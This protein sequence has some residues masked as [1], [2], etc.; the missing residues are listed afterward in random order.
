MSTGS[1]G[2]LT[3]LGLR[4]EDA[5]AAPSISANFPSENRDFSVATAAQIC[6]QILQ[7]QDNIRENARQ[8]LLSLSREGDPDLFYESLFHLARREARLH[9]AAA[10]VGS[11]FQSLAEDRR[12]A[13]P[14][15]L[16][17]RAREELAL[18]QG[19]GSFGRRFENFTTHFVEEA[20]DPSMIAGMALGGIAFSAVRLGVM[21]RFAVRPAAWW[22]RGLGA[23]FLASSA[24][25]PA[26]VL[27]FWGSGRAIN[28]VRHPGSLRWDGETLRNELISQTLTLGLL[29][30]SGAASTRLF[31][32]FHGI[33]P[34]TGQALRLPAFTHFSRQAFHQLGMFGGIVGGHYVETRLQLRPDTGN[35]W[36][37]SLMTL[38]H[39]NVGGRVANTV[40]GPGHAAR[41]R[42]IELQTQRI[43]SAVEPRSGSGLFGSQ[44]I[45]A[46]TP[47]GFRVSVPRKDARLGPSIVQMSSHEGGESRS[48]IPH[49]TYKSVIQGIADE[50][51]PI[52]Q[53]FQMS[54]SLMN[55][56]E[57]ARRVYDTDFAR[58]ARFTNWR[59]L[60]VLLH[61]VNKRHF[62]TVSNTLFEWNDRFRFLQNELRSQVNTGGQRQRRQVRRLLDSVDLKFLETRRYLNDAESYLGD[63]KGFGDGARSKSV[64]APN[65]YQRMLIS[66]FLDINLRLERYVQS[67]E[68]LEGIFKG[69]RPNPI[70]R[71]PQRVEAAQ[72]DAEIQAIALVPAFERI[73]RRGL[74][75]GDYFLTGLENT[76]LYRMLQAW[77]A[78]PNHRATARGKRALERYL[79]VIDEVQQ[80]LGDRG[81]SQ[82]LEAHEEIA[83]DRIQTDAFRARIENV[84]KDHGDPEALTSHYIRAAEGL[85]GHLAEHRPQPRAP[86]LP[87]WPELRSQLLRLRDRG[88][89]GSDAVNG[90]LTWFEP[91]PK[92]RTSRLILN[93]RRE[94]ASGLIDFLRKGSHSD[95]TRRQISNF[96]G[97]VV[98][99]K[100]QGM[101]DIL[102]IY[103]QTYQ[104]GMMRDRIQIRTRPSEDPLSDQ[105]AVEAYDH[106]LEAMCNTARFYSANRELRGPYFE[107]FLKL[108]DS[109]DNHAL[110][111]API[112]H[113][114]ERLIEEGFQVQLL[115]R[116]GSG[117]GLISAVHPRGG[118]RRTITVS[119][120]IHA[121][122][123]REHLEQ[124]LNRAER[125][126]LHNG[127]YVGNGN[128]RL[129]LAL[130]IPHIRSGVRRENLQIWARDYLE[131]HP[132]LAE[133]QLNVPKRGNTV[134]NPTD[135]TFFETVK[136]TREALTTE[137][138][139]GSRLQALN[140]D[141]SP[142]PEFAAAIQMRRGWADYLAN[143][144]PDLFRIFA[145]PDPVGFLE[146]RSQL[147]RDSLAAQRS[148]EPSSE[149]DTAQTLIRIDSLERRLTQTE[150]LL[151]AARRAQGLHQDNWD[152]LREIAPRFSD[153][154]GYRDL[155]KKLWEERLRTLDRSGWNYLDTEGPAGRPEPYPSVEVRADI[156]RQVSGMVVG[157]E[158]PSQIFPQ[159]FDLSASGYRTGAL[160]WNFRQQ[161]LGLEGE[162]FPPEG[163]PPA[164]VDDAAGLREPD[165]GTFSLRFHQERGGARH[166]SFESLTL[167]SH[168]QGN[169]VGTRY[170]GELLRLSSRMGLRTIESPETS[171]DHRYTM[172]LYGMNFRAQ[173]EL[174]R[175]RNHFELFLGGRLRGFDLSAVGNIRTLRDIAVAYVDPGTRTLIVE[176]AR[177]GRALRE[178]PDHLRVGREFLL[179]QAPSYHGIFDLRP[180]SQSRRIFSDYWNSRFSEPFEP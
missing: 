135:G 72:L 154:S 19:G 43:G 129:V 35:L 73:L 64:F 127:N 171:G 62:E 104:L 101:L 38:V 27:A 7:M 44:E 151:S 9:N 24:A 116:G 75:Q 156:F 159:L 65:N 97:E 121:L 11:V 26:E 47:E 140:L 161:R 5:P 77:N 18:L 134:V 98:G 94:A 16:R 84:L 80:Q 162:L 172:A 4:F 37:D 13:V 48:S 117:E 20:T 103:F 71:R 10:W 91:S 54:Q 66:R 132:N 25:L 93:M 167:P 146:T 69:Y 123:S 33:S 143:R 30:L 148:A 28:A 12:E 163:T 49:E 141:S 126:L 168:L 82:W 153:H 63:D 2:G 81:R 125:E 176:P 55:H 99:R 102:S 144:D 8:E 124:W 175:S 74:E 149:V 142:W 83:G 86:A 60:D 23:R 115:G 177:N 15:S 152:L 29:K 174:R 178:I 79:Q 87:E 179:T 31:D 1:S 51:I 78:Y 95:A 169:G 173:E 165:T 70:D 136:V 145:H 52:V 131:D 180:G 112:L 88:T 76:A 68:G 147:V 46:V 57:D 111:A 122:E 158:V 139:L 6:A 32:H 138:A 56:L 164:P 89:L 118:E 150:D 3:N 155:V 108:E 157:A 67:K 133:I 40:L 50:T 96:L 114:T 58:T 41:V 106:F 36:S 42:A 92:A 53:R 34:L 128:S 119:S 22:T 45:F 120:V 109:K 14:P 105:L 130:Q 110:L 39:F 59:S 17:A 107:V 90:L 113:Q 100:D 21:T 137:S 166:V 170:F 85:L 160:R 61:A